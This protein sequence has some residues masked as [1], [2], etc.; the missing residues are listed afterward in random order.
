M[1]PTRSSG[2]AM[3]RRK[4]G[5]RGAHPSYSVMMTSKPKHKGPERNGKNRGKGFAKAGPDPV[6]KGKRA[7]YY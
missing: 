5:K 7:R 4:G 3:G 1:L 6:G 2:C